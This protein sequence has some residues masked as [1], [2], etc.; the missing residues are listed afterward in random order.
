M[1]DTAYVSFRLD[2]R[3]L[4]NPVPFVVTS[5]HLYNLFLAININ[6]W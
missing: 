6:N 5:D 1:D 3:L 2:D 4:W